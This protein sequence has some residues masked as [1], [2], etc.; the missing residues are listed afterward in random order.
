[1]LG[2]LELLN[3]RFREIRCSQKNLED[4]EIEKDLGNLGIKVSIA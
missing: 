2:R 1:M 3:N 4:S